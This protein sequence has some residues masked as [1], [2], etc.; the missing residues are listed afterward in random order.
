MQ[1]PLYF[2][3]NVRKKNE[4][5]SLPMLHVAPFPL[6]GSKLLPNGKSFD[7]E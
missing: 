3:G 4:V 2:Y 1:Q 5:A 7:E 6:N